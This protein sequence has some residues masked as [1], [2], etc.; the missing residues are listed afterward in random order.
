M[1][2]NPMAATINKEKIMQDVRGMYLQKG[3]Y[4]IYAVEYYDSLEQRI[5]LIIDVDEKENKTV[6]RV[7]SARNNNGT[8]ERVRSSGLT[9]RKGIFAVAHTHIPD[10]IQLLLERK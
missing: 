2:S 3:M 5:G 1:G 10:E 9:N 6:L 8:W 7:R 4:I